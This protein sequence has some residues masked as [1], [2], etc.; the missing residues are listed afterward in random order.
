[1]GGFM[2][3]ARSRNYPAISLGDAIERA[4]A[5]YKQEGRAAAPAEVVVRAWGYNSLNGA[6]LRVLSALR[7]YGLLEGSN[8]G[9]RLSPRA[10]TLLLEPESHPEYADALH[11]ALQSPALFQDIVAEYGDD[12]PSDPALV[13]YLVRKQNFGEAA[14]KTL[15]EAFRESADLVKGKTAGYIPHAQPVSAAQS[16]LDDLVSKSRDTKE[17][18]PKMARPTK[19]FT[20]PLSDDTVVTLGITGPMPRGEDLEA[21][22]DW[23][24]LVKRQIDRAAVTPLHA[25]I[26]APPLEPEGQ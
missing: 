7:Q 26:H 12:L 15:I 14:A 24:A 21:L 10:L 2:A 4:K 16:W 22:T 11:E 5:L 23:L 1:M 18:E 17:L 3:R 13:S 20:F 9:I 19:E 6:S 8:E 25:L